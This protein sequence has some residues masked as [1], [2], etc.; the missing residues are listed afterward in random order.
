MRIGILLPHV[1]AQQ[2]LLD[3]VIFAPVH[4]AVNLADT[5]S[6]EHHVV[7]FSP[8]E[9]DTKAVN[10]TVDMALL[11][12]EVKKES[13]TFSQL[14]IKNPLAFVSLSRQVQAE[15]TAKAFEMANNDE[16]DIVHVFMCESEIP[17]YF[18]DLVDIPVVFTHHDPYNF[19]RKYRVTFP[20]R[21]NLNYVS[22]SLNQ[23][24]TAPKGTKF[25]GNVYNGVDLSKFRFVKKSGE[26]YSSLGRIIRNKGIHTA[27]AACQNTSSVLRIAGKHYSS[28]K[29][30]DDYWEKY[31]KP[32]ID[33]ENIFYDGFISDQKDRSEFL[34]GA[35]AM[36][37]PIE[38]S[39]PFG[40]VV[41][42]S[43]A[44]GTPVIAFDSGPVREL[45]EDGKTGFV[46]KTLAQM[47]EAMQ[48][49]DQIDRKYCRKS[50]E[51]R[52][53]VDVM[54]HGYEEVYKKLVKK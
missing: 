40:M 49:I 53:T 43:L 41:V 36:L 19:Y 39:E 30:G 54:S 31:V 15:L 12:E 11:N 18:S 24:N 22:I 29:T 10:I 51:E 32:H 6:I 46:V 25:V 5:L 33:S 8:G 14:I 37:F 4:L 2:S 21:K 48:K 45:I 1:F 35:K 52:F 27:I 13:C 42:E 20:K 3:K 16:L 7:L 50:V 23:R 47:E 34:G 28:E 9:L 17:L 26:Y 38:W 44:C